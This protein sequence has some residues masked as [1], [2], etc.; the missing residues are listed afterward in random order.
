MPTNTRSLPG[1][2]SLSVYAAFGVN[3]GNL[4]SR[5]FRATD[6][7]EWIHEL[8]FELK[9]SGIQI[10]RAYGHTGN[11]VVHA[12]AADP[13]Q[14]QGRL[15]SAT[16][17]EW[18]VMSLPDLDRCLQALVARQPPAKSEGDRWTAG[19]VLLVRGAARRGSLTDTP[20]AA[21]QRFSDTAVLAWKRDALDATGTRLDN[22]R[23]R[24][25]WGALSSDIGRQLGGTWTAR[26]AR[27][28]RGLR[29]VAG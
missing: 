13:A 20:R 14:I 5:S 3:I 28:L 11:F 25:G 22:E 26:S 27:T 16:G 21:F 7:S 24:G 6:T 4:T 2:S 15:A 8:S 29:A 23:R 12:K 19:A 10:P 9:S 18:A 1:S 17:A